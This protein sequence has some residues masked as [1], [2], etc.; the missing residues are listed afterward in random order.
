MVDVIV[1]VREVGRLR[2][3]AFLRFALPDV[4]AVGS[5]ISVQ[6]PEASGPFGI[7]LIVRQVWW[8][9]HHPELDQ[10]FSVPSDKT[11]SLNEVFIECD[12]A[13]GPWSSEEWRRALGTNQEVETFEAERPVPEP[14]QTPQ[15]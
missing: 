11:G 1:V 6:R 13:L 15:S 5:Y 10:T 14:P 12:P 9:L 4:P 7:D 8:R 2:P 3:Q